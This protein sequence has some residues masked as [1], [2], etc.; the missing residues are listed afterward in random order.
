MKTMLPKSVKSRLVISRAVLILCALISA[1]MLVLA[2]S[3][4]MERG[5]RE[6]VEIKPKAHLAA[7]PSVNQSGINLNTATKEE[8]M[9]L[10]GIGKYLAEQL[11]LKREEQRFYFLEDI[12]TV[13]G[14]GD[15]RINSL[16]PHAFVPLPPDPENPG[17]GESSGFE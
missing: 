6:R 10:P 8:L 12:G 2:V 11:I 13:K 17:A 14:F 5:H 16:K 1:G 4:A 15:K 7:L 3:G 9:S